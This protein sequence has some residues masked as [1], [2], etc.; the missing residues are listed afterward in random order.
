MTLDQA[1]EA[2]LRIVQAAEELY[3]H[4]WAA[5][6][7]ERQAKSKLRDATQY[8]T[9]VLG[10][11]ERQTLMSRISTLEISKGFLET[12]LRKHKDFGRLKDEAKTK[13]EGKWREAEAQVERLLERLDYLSEPARM[14][15]QWQARVDELQNRVDDLNDQSALIAELRAQ[16]TTQAQVVDQLNKDLTAA[17]VASTTNRKLFNAERDK[18]ARVLRAAKG[19][20]AW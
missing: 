5:S 13:V 11:D 8:P 12:E 19:E 14:E 2:Q 18:V 6:D 7:A 1:K 20:S 15:R 3:R 9:P 16:N 10:K 17:R 4:A